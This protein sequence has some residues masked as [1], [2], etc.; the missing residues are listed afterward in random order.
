MLLGKPPISAIYFNVH[1]LS[2]KIEII[3]MSDL[4]KLP[5]SRK[6]VIGETKNGTIV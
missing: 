1:F 2:K 4:Y 6:T 5:Y 3:E